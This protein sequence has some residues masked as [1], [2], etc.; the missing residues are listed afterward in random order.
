M[1]TAIYPK[2]SEWRI[3]DL[4]VHSPASCSVSGGFDDFVIQLGNSRCDVIGINDYFSVEGYKT[5]KSYLDGTAT[6]DQVSDAYTDALEKLRAKTI[7]PVVECR[8][9][10]IVQGRD[11][12]GNPRI[13]FHIIFDNELAI[14]EIETLLRAF[15][16]SDRSTIG[17]NYSNSDFLLNKVSVDFDRVHEK[18]NQN[19]KLKDRHL[20]WIPYD[21]YG[22]IGDINPNS[23]SMLKEGFINKAD[24]LGSSNKNQADFFL[25]KN[26][27]FTDDQFRE[28]FGR[29]K[30]CI[31]GSDSHSLKDKIGNLKDDR[32]QPTNKFCWIKA[33]PTFNGLKQIVHEPENRVFIGERPPKLVHFEQRKFNYLTRIEIRPNT[34]STTDMGWFDTELEL[35]HDMIAVIGNKGNGKSALLDILALAGNTKNVSH[36]S[37]LSKNKFR[38]KSGRLAGQF[39]VTATW[40]DGT[41]TSRKL[42][43]DPDRDQTERVRYLPQS[44]LE[45]I[46]TETT[47]DLKSQ[48]QQ[49]IRNVIFSHIEKPDRLGKN[50]LDD[51][52]DYHVEEIR[53]QISQLKTEIRKLNHDIVRFEMASTESALR[54]LESKLKEKNDQL[55]AFE[56]QKPKEVKAPSGGSEDEQLTALKNQIGEKQ[57]QLKKLNQQIETEKR[58]QS[59]LT[60]KTAV[61]KK[62]SEKLKGLED[63]IRSVK[64]DISE[65][66]K[67]MTLSV[68]NVITHNIQHS[69]IAKKITDLENELGK[70]R[71]LLDENLPMS[72]VGQS[73]KLEKELTELKKKLDE[74]TRLYQAYLKELD[75][76]N[77]RKAEL[78]G[79]AE[80]PD[81]LKYIEKQI[82]DHKTIPGKIGKLEDNRKELCRRIHTELKGIE[83]IYQTLFAPLSEL[84][85][86]HPIIADQMNAHS[87][88]IRHPIPI[89][90]GTPFQ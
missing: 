36:F 16:L 83:N 82:S 62:V 34:S 18:L 32:S 90:S 14:E 33:D 79:D 4:H 51:L 50:S 54:K 13:N 25:W 44:Y 7:L 2:G 26:K 29:K 12:K 47:P 42:N 8:M 55:K 85:R 43:E 27:K 61:A 21:E 75:I 37:F 39:T 35:N 31:K 41:Q 9:T 22:G 49:E 24:I 5:V 17:S 77:K 28:W 46:C 68:D 23:D 30:A 74:P 45:K 1:T 86:T 60:Q 69:V 3:W 6:P 59:D 52:I 65:D 71:K 76:W 78:V 56:T 53:D 40:A 87:G 81:S 67:Q 89:L 70:C 38:E 58:R 20:I 84:I 10:N 66:L 63:R 64:S 48:F 15:D 80:S 73:K 19:P 72:L 57:D 11:G 88:V